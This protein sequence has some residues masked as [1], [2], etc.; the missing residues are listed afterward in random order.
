[1]KKSDL[2]T[3]NEFAKMCRTTVRTIRFYDKM[4]LLTPVRI[5]EW[6]KYRYYSPYQTRDFFRIRLLQTFKVP[7][8][9]VRET[10]S[11]PYLEKKIA[12]VR[13]ELLEKRKEYNFLLRINKFFFDK[14]DLKKELKEESFGQHTLFGTYTPQGAYHKINADIERVDREARR[15][16]IKTTG[17]QII[18]YLDPDKYKPKNTRLEITTICKKIP[19]AIKIPKGFFVR[20]FRKTRGLAFAYRGP[21]EFITL[22]YERLHEHDNMEKFAVEKY[23]FDYEIYGTLNKKSPYDHLTKIVFP[24]G[25]PKS[26]SNRHEGGPLAREG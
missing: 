6:N 16:G 1:M 25:S 2:I 24:F 23:P 19:K 17:R 7:L 12:Q 8:K 26:R 9:N 20:K 11:K 15:I 10:I 3:I 5:D 4:G 22:V 21:S 14:V 13:Q 18:F